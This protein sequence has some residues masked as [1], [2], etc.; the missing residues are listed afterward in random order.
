MRRQVYR[1]RLLW[2]PDENVFVLNDLPAEMSHLH[3]HINSC[4]LH[5][6][7]P[8]RATVDTHTKREVCYPKRKHKII[9]LSFHSLS[10]QVW[11]AARMVS[12]ASSN[13]QIGSSYT[14]PWSSSRCRFSQRH[15]PFHRL[16]SSSWRLTTRFRPCDARPRRVHPDQRLFP[17]FA[18]VH[19]IYHRDLDLRGRLLPP[20]RGTS[21]S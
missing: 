16:C 20:I 2:D 15:P 10:P 17:M 19:H 1:R 5:L 9:T 6:L 7:L 8:S 21:P 13:S 4:L 11:L 12:F 18:A 3:V 14:S